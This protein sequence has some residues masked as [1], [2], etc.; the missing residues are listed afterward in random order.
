MPETRPR[1]PG[2][3]RRLNNVELVENIIAAATP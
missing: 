1:S 2:D 3:R